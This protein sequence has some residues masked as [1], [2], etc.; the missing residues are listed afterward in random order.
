[1][2][3]IEKMKLEKSKKKIISIRVEM[4][5]YEFLKKNNFLASKIFREAI[6]DLKE[7]IIENEKYKENTMVSYYQSKKK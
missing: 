7:K 3:D 2:M 1:M 5:D 6:I 4:E